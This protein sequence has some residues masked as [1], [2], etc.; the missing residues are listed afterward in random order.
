[1]TCY[2]NPDFRGFKEAVYPLSY[3]ELDG[4]LHTSVRYF[5]FR[6]YPPQ[7][8]AAY[9]G[10]SSQYKDSVQVFLEQ[11]DLIRRMVAAHPDHLLQARSADDVEERFFML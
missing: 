9:Y 4:L 7:F 3:R 2:I 1:M 6:S 10:C 8:W 5:H 11:I